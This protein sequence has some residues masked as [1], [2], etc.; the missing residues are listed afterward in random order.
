MTDKEIIDAYFTDPDVIAMMD[1]ELGP[2]G[3]VTVDYDKGIITVRGQRSGR[4]WDLHKFVK[5]LRNNSNPNGRQ[6][7]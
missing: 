5:D 1:Q 6:N 7:E 4:E 3:K 2:P